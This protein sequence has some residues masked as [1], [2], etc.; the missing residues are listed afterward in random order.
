VAPR[1]RLALALLAAGL[2]ACAG[3]A[4]RPPLAAEIQAL[5]GPPRGATLAEVL[6]SL[7]AAPGAEARVSL[8]ELRMIRRDALRWEA[9]SRERTAAEQG[10]LGV[11]AH[12]A[13]GYRQGLRRV[14][15]ER[16]SWYAF[17][18]GRLAAFDHAAFDPGCRVQR[19]FAPAEAAA[20]ETERTLVRFAAQRY[21]GSVLDPVEQLQLGLALV[22]V[23]RIDEARAGLRSGDHAL[24]ALAHERERTRAEEREALELR[25]RELRALRARLHH[26][27]VRAEAERGS[28]EEP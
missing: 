1:L 2:A 16:A 21:P 4:G 13:C 22:A 15:E 24:E 3:P 14:R 11:I 7:E 6:A 17:E 27:L 28:T 20:L 12:R 10:A 5:P 18:D 25:E 23:G 9:V 19:R 26:A 8:L